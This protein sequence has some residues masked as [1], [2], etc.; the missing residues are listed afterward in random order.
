M[1]N[2]NTTITSPKWLVVENSDMDSSERLSVDDQRFTVIEGGVRKQIGRAVGSYHHASGLNKTL[3]SITSRYALFFDPD[4]FIVKPNWI[5]DIIAHM[6]RRQLSLFGVPYYPDRNAKYRYF[7]CVICLFIDLGSIMKSDLD[8]S[9]EIDEMEI[10]SSLS[11][12]CL[13]E[14]VL[15]DQKPN[16]GQLSS[17]ITI[18]MAREALRNRLMSRLLGRFAGLFRI[19]RSRDTGWLIYQSYYGSDKYLSECVVPVWKN[20]LFTRPTSLKTLVKQTIARWILPDRNSP[21]PKQRYYTTHLS[22][23]DFGFLD[24]STVNAEEYLWQGEPFGFHIRGAFQGINTIDFPTLCKY[25][26]QFMLSKIAYT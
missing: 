13:I 23:R 21:Y 4:F 5:R 19:G 1:L 25:T 9:P 10:A 22:F 20:P 26:K 11:L 3:D 14:W 24:F 2:L 12:K 18:E 15:A 7:P 8:I 17:K 16:Y 6:Q